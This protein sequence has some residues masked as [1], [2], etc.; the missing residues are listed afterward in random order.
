[1]DAVVIY[2]KDCQALF[3][4]NSRPRV[5]DIPDIVQYALEGHEVAVVDVEIVRAELASCRC[6]SQD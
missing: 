2:C 3:Y 6:T 4:A 5:E 1:M